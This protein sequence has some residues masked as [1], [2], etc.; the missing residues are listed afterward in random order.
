MLYLLKVIKIPIFLQ[1]TIM[2]MPEIARF[3]EDDCEKFKYF[4]V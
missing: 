1:L 4:T 2:K 3:K